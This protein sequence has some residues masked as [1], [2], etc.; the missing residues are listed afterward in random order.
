MSLK[1]SIA[2]F[3]GEGEKA[4]PF[5]NAL[6]KRANYTSPPNSEAN[7][8]AIVNH[9][10]FEMMLARNFYNR[11]GMQDND[12]HN[13][14]VD[15]VVKTALLHRHLDKP[16]T[17]HPTIHKMKESF[18]KTVDNILGGRILDNQNLSKSTIGN[19]LDEATLKNITSNIN[20]VTITPAVPT[21]PG[22]P[23]R[24]V[25]TALEL[26]NEPAGSGNSLNKSYFDY[27][28]ALCYLALSELA[29]DPNAPSQL[30]SQEIDKLNPVFSQMAGNCG[31]RDT[32]HVRS[33]NSPNIDIHEKDTSDF[34]H[35]CWTTYWDKGS[36]TSAVKNLINLFRHAQTSGKTSTVDLNKSYNEFLDNMHKNF[37]G[38]I[39]EFAL[40]MCNALGLSNT[41]EL[42]SLWFGSVGTA[43]VPPRQANKNDIIKMF[44]QRILTGPNNQKLKNVLVNALKQSSFASF[45]EVAAKSGM[46]LYEDLA[47]D[48]YAKSFCQHIL[49]RWVELHTQARTF[50]REHLAIFRRLPVDEWGTQ[51]LLLDDGWMG[52]FSQSGLQICDVKDLRLNLAKM[53]PTSGTLLFEHTLPY[54][55]VDMVGDLWYTDINKKVT[56]IS[57]G[58]FG[59]DVLKLIY[60][61]VYLGEKS[62]N[63]G[64]GSSIDLPNDL[65]QDEKQQ[66]DHKLTLV[67]KNMMDNFNGGSI[68]KGGKK[69]TLTEMFDYESNTRNW[70]TDGETF[71]KQDKN[72]NMIT[73][74]EFIKNEYN[75]KNSLSL[76][77][78]DEKG[79]VIPGADRQCESVAT[80]LLQSPGRLEDC[81][82]RFKSSE[83]FNVAQNELR[84]NMDP[85]MAVKLLRDIFHV[86]FETIKMYNENIERPVLFNTWVDEVLNSPHVP[87]A[88]W[89]NEFRN[90]LGKNQ[91]L[92][93][94]IDGL[95]SFI[96]ENPAVLNKNKIVNKIY[97]QDPQ[98]VILNNTTKEN[99][100]VLGSYTYPNEQFSDEKEVWKYRIGTL[101]NTAGSVFMPAPSDLMFRRGIP[102]VVGTGLMSPFGLNTMSGGEL[103]YGEAECKKHNKNLGVYLKDLMENL[104]HK[105]GMRFMPEEELE[106]RKFCDQLV[107]TEK[108]ILEMVKILENLQNLQNFVGCYDNGRHAAT[109][110]GK[111]LSLEDIVSNKDLLAWLNHNIGDYQNCI[112]RGMEYINAGSNQ[113]LKSYQDLIQSSSKK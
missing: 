67:V 12:V 39:K 19:I 88:G 28:C 23:V 3:F 58:Q 80:C 9:E 107:S 47:S 94:Y 2:L 68:M 14:F 27:L 85:F 104:K 63:L 57:K 74:N 62:A 11:N 84:D 26:L 97:E 30:I 71:Y 106:I 69:R 76:N 83:M 38:A 79:N 102:A 31:N 48:K 33:I 91:H 100:Y 109:T 25:V 66:W 8:E 22:A 29:T 90:N 81:L 35:L 36:P 98:I 73:R 82:S 93:N 108:T 61:S 89:T 64:R 5:F 99:P 21:G 105:G 20:K 32:R 113:V 40:E 60:K 42:Y 55:P 6:Y 37:I 4:L 17:T 46:V 50:Y 51:N 53:N 54:V 7:P 72:G 78:K 112:Y 110:S 103:P 13:Q 65:P 87:P 24:T 96:R 111:V 52:K 34:S 92:L 15:F 70:F 77:L 16:T 75:C 44:H 10:I 56:K 18:D 95:I 49:T 43:G 45:K 101:A 59:P 86:R 1:D 41:H